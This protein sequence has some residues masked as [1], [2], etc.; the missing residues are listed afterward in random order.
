MPSG[1]VDR[2]WCMLMWALLG[3]SACTDN[4][5]VPPKVGAPAPK[6]IGAPLPPPAPLQLPSFADM[7]AK[8]RPAVV[9]IY[10]KT[11]TAPPKHDRFFGPFVP[12]Q[13]VQDSLGSG[14]IIEASGLVLTN[15]HVVQGATEIEVR[16]LDE[17]RFAAKVVGLDPK[18]DVALLQLELAS[19]L[20]ALALGSSQALR[21]GDWVVAIGNPLGLTSTVTAGIASATGRRHMALGGDLMYQ[22]FIQTDASINPGNSGGPLLNRK[23]EVVGINTAVNAEGQGLGF[24][25]PIDMVKDLLPQLKAGRIERS[26][27]GVYTA[28]VPPVVS[29]ELGLK[30]RGALVAEVI[31]GAP[32]E[33][34]KLQAGDIIVKF[35]GT[36]VRSEDHLRWIAGLIGPGKRVE[37][38]IRRG[39]QRMMTRILMAPMPE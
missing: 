31:P 16:L 28:S 30:T 20:P 39:S 34:A 8:T 35:N 7:V 24:A 14:F 38:E 21:V 12:R 3:L 13:R 10:T 23:G 17:R 32:A 6:A 18:T 29:K 15:T 27:I 33:R 22:D 1:P 36:Q 19:S 2:M 11:R 9:N 26:W 4:V 5:P 37:V 25:I